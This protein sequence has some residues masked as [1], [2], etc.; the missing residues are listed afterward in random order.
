MDHYEE[1]L[2]DCRPKNELEEIKKTEGISLEIG[3]V[4]ILKR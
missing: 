4:K 1:E 2:R 3:G